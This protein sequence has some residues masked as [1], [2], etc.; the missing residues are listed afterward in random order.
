MTFAKKI[1]VLVLLVVL[2]APIVGCGV[3]TSPAENRRAC[4][5]V[6]DYDARMMVDDLAI[7]LQID[8]P[9]R[10]SRWVID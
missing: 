8:R 6:V 9:I 1:L 5:R 2:T 7:F 3:A 10:N 4:N